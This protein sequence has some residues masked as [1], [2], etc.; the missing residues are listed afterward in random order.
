MFI[1]IISLSLITSLIFGD[2]VRAMEP[3]NDERIHSQRHISVKVVG[4]TEDEEQVQRLLQRKQKIEEE[5]RQ[6]LE[7]LEVLESQKT[8]HDQKQEEL[9][10]EETQI[11]EDLAKIALQKQNLLSEKQRQEEEELQWLK[12]RQQ[13]ENKLRQEEGDY[14]RQVEEARL[15]REG[16]NYRHQQEFKSQMIVFQHQEDVLLQQRKVAQK[17]L[18]KIE[19]L[20]KELQEKQGRNAQL[21]TDENAS[22]NT[23]EEKFRQAIQKL[24]RRHDELKQEKKDALE[25]LKRIEEEQK[26]LRHQRQDAAKEKERQWQAQRLVVEGQ[27]TEE[28]VTHHCR[29][30]DAR[31]RR[32]EE[33]GRYQ[34]TLED[35]KEV[36]RRQEEECRESERRAQKELR[37]LSFQQE[38][39]E[40]EKIK[41]AE[42][43]STAQ[44]K[45]DACR[46]EKE[47]NSTSSPTSSVLSSSPLSTFSSDL[48]KSSKTTSSPSS[49]PEKELSISEPLLSKRNKKK[50]FPPNNETTPLLPKGNFSLQDINTWFLIEESQVSFPSKNKLF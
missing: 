22:A 16:E 34:Q 49:S 21:K 19:L 18:E 14:Q 39:L 13:E 20:E 35:Q 29:V 42:D 47:K 33:D 23:E 37:D 27:L 1:R 45:L 43:T 3:G 41:W 15:S 26:K 31:I 7:S 10:K 38:V 6:W 17:T 44:L 12:N 8:N 40:G 30:E 50:A 2:V 36:L 5:E 32:E 9:S 11:R 28:A 4:N 25:V 24:Q 48:S 46:L